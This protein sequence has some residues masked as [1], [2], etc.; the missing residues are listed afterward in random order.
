MDRLSERVDGAGAEM[1]RSLF[2]VEAPVVLNPDA[3]S[4]QVIADW[5]RRSGGCA[6]GSLGPGGWARTLV[7]ADAARSATLRT[8]F[9]T[10]VLFQSPDF[11]FKL[12]APVELGATIADASGLVRHRLE[13]LP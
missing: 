5:V 13:P 2:T 8:P 10:L 6:S 4:E 9:A 7:L 3:P 1:L 12:M 11:D